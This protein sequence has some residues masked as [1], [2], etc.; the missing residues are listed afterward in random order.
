MDYQQAAER[1]I[2]Y[3]DRASG[4]RL[5]TAQEATLNSLTAI[6]YALLHLAEVAGRLGA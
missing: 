2:G 5:D 3:V 1:Y 4:D 6:T